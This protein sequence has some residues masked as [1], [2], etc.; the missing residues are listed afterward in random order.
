MRLLADLDVWPALMRHAAP[1]RAIRM[2]DATGGLLRAPETTFYA[3]ELGLRAFGFNIPNGDLVEALRRH[4][5]AFRNLAVYDWPVERLTSREAGVAL[6]AE[7]IEATARLAIAADGAHS[8]AREA[9]GI[10]VRTWSHRQAALVATLAIEQPH[11]GVST[12]FHT[13]GGPFTLVPL[14]GDRVSL[15]WVDRPDR[16]DAC[17]SLAAEAFGRA[18][19]KQAHFIH[20]GMRLDSA[21]VVFPLRAALADRFAARRIMLVGEA[22]HVLP[23]IGAQG[24]N[25]GF[26]DVAALR[27]ILSRYA[28]DPGAPAALAAFHDARRADVRSRTLAVDFLNRSLL[29]D[30]LPAQAA[31][32]LTLTLA[33][34]IPALRRALMRQGLGG[35]PAER[36]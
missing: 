36:R 18:V 21:P 3:S 8:R 4:A 24:L 27:R 23:P 7:G 28:D 15:V 22:A 14:P 25:L 9:A 13:A 32:G 5:Q 11:N 30:F 17:A 35:R 6:G 2:I 31:R 34:G 10:G 12:E 1:L 26:R 19:E 29:V 33:A 20:G 16:I